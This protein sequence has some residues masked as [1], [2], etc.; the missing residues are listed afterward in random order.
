MD[1]YTALKS[2]PNTKGKPIGSPTTANAQNS[3]K[4]APLYDYIDANFHPYAG[5][6][7]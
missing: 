1:T 7:E 2:N 3:Y 5:M 4:L 6:K